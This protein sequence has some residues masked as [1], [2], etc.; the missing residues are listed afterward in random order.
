MDV[1]SDVLAVVRL[2]GAIFVDVD[3]TAPWSAQSPPTSELKRALPGS[4]HLMSYHLVTAGEVWATPTSGEALRLAAGTM[5]I[6]P[7][8]SA[9]AVGSDPSL[10]PGAA[11]ET[12]HLPVALSRPYVIRGGGNGP[13]RAKLICGFFGCDAQP[14]NPLLSS[15]PEIIILSASDDRSGDLGVFVRLAVAEVNAG[16]P[17]GTAMLG[18]LGELMLI[19]ALRRYMRDDIE[20]TSGWIRG[21]RDPNIGRAIASIHDDPLQ[22]WTLESLA[23]QAGMSRTKFAAAFHRLVEITP[24]EYVASWRLQRAAHCLAS[25]GNIA[26]A[27]MQAGYESESSFSRAFRKRTGVAPGAWRKTMLG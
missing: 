23:R 16:S 20:E 13:E 4:R 25:G 11:I 18:R 2:S 9:H 21:M 8:G 24:M 17:G 19:E 1:L 22:A 10:G 7:H 12:S 5:V 3:V 6:F 15:L 14:F 26:E 27:A